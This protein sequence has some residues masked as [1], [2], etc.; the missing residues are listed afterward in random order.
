MVIL[1]YFFDGFDFLTNNQPKI[2]SIFY[3]NKLSVFI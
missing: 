2:A 1:I 3:T